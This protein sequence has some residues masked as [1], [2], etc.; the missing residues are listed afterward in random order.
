MMHHKIRVQVQPQLS[1][2]LE[3]ILSCKRMFQNKVI[4]SYSTKN[5]L[6]NKIVVKVVL[7]I[8]CIVILIYLFMI[9][10]LYIKL[11]EIFTAN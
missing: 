1:S 7:P 6:K 10:R 3:A 5:T 8:F 2:E 11:H 9:C 4:Y